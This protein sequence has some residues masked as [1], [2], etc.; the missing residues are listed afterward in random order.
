MMDIKIAISYK[1]SKR[2]NNLLTVRR[3]EN[4]NSLSLMTLTMKKLDKNTNQNL[5][6]KKKEA[7]KKLRQPAP[8]KRQQINNLM[9]TRRTRTLFTRALSSY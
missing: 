9:N 4:S 3:F 8:P 6:L 7:P 2:V 5:K 1:L